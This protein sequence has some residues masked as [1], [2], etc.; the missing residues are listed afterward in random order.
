MAEMAEWVPV[1]TTHDEMEAEFLKGLL[2][3]AGVPVVLETR[4][5]KGLP[6]VYGPNASGGTT[7]RVPPDQAEFARQLLAAQA[8]APE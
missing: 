7:L 8:E 4:G 1:L 3:G 5:F 6:S 2:E